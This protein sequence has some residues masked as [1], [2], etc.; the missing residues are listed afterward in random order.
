[1]FGKNCGK[2]FGSIFKFKGKIQGGGEPP[3]K[4]AFT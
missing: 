1:M 4:R 2:L 3:G